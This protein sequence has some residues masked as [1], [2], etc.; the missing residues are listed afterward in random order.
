MSSATA[1]SLSV[2]I[3]QLRRE[4][5]EAKKA[6]N[7]EL[8]FVLIDKADTLERQQWTEIENLEAKPRPM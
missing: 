7:Y 5:D 3:E 1:I 4:A 2:Q 6:L 8:A